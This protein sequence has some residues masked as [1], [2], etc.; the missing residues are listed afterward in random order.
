MP[1]H[2][3]IVLAK[4]QSTWETIF[5]HWY[6]PPLAWVLKRELLWLPLF[7]WALATLEPIAINRKSSSEAMRQL[8]EQGKACLDKGRWVMI[9]PEGTRTAPGHRRRYKLGGARLAANT[10]YPVLPIA[11]NA[12]EFWRR[13]SLIKYPGTIQVVIGPLIETKGLSPQEINDKTEQWIENTMQ[14]ISAVP[15]AAQYDIPE[16]PNPAE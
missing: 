2:A 6:L 5:F 16:K 3:V 10:G 9:F 14:K 15:A 12:G 13:R 7:G 4:H 11:H 1:D 8:F